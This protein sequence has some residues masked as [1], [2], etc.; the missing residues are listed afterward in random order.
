MQGFTMLLARPR[1]PL[2]RSDRIRAA[3]QEPS[4]DCLLRRRTIHHGSE[5]RQTSLAVQFS[6]SASCLSKRGMLAQCTWKHASEAR[7]WPR[8]ISNQASLAPA[9]HKSSSILLRCTI[10]DQ[11]GTPRVVSGVFNKAE[12]CAE[13]HIEFRDLR[14]IDSRVPNLVPTILARRGAF[15]VNVLHIRALIKTDE[16]LL[17]DRYEVTSR[18]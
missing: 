6:A 2:W 16:V 7:H 5:R 18:G 15:L 10:F 3:A 4:S 9:G 12:L 8:S 11:K 1:A 14:K 13:H 17:F